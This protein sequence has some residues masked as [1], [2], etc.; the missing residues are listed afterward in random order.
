M[1]GSVTDEKGEPLVGAT[2]SVIGSG[3]NTTTGV[4]GNFQVQVA[5]NARQLEITY[6]GFTTQRV[7]IG[8]RS[9][10]AIKLAPANSNLSEVVVVAYGTVKK[11]ALTG[12][13]GQIGAKQIRDR[14]H[15]QRYQCGGRCGTGCGGLFGK[16]A[17]WFGQ[18][19]PGKG[20]WIGERLP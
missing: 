19:H 3:Q 11:E 17:A 18:C 20:V 8:S 15:Q 9:T 4:T 10:L 14:P 6:A 13:V 12:S 2:I 16:R 7:T 1:N 5:A